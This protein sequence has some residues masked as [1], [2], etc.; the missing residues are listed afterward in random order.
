MC[1]DVR[2]LLIPLHEQELRASDGPGRTGCRLSRRHA[3]VQQMQLDIQQFLERWF[4][5]RCAET[6]AASDHR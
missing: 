6:T 3:E 2:M 4:A 1:F 5:A